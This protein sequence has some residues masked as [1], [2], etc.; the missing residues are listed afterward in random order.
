MLQEVQQQ[1]L[2]S[3]QALVFKLAELR[4]QNYSLRERFV[5]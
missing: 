4:A 3:K 5:K 2:E 1:M